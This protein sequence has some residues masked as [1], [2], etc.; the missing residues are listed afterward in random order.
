MSRR[1]LLIEQPSLRAEVALA[2]LIPTTRSFQLDRVEWDSLVI[3]RV[4]RSAAELILAVAV[5]VVNKAIAWLEWLR[6]HPSPTPSFVILPAQADEAVL[7]LAADA[8]DEFM[9]WPL[10]PEEF[11]QRLRRILHVASD[12][13]ESTHERLVQDLGLGQLVGSDPAF[14]RSIQAIPLVAKSD[15]PALITGESGTGKELCARAIHHLSRRRGCPFV[16]VDCSALPD[17]LFE[18]ELFGHSRGAY[19]DAHADQKGLVAI[20]DGGTLFLDEVDSLSLGSQAKILRFLQERTFKPLGGERFHRAD[21]NII[22]ASNADLE[23]LV[24]ERR[25]RA[26][27]FF[28]LN[29]LRLKLPPVRER[30][31]DIETLAYHVLRSIPSPDGRPRR[32][33]SKGAVRKLQLYD[34][35]GNVRELSNIVQRA[36]LL[37][38]GFQILPE[39]IS[40]PESISLSERQHGPFRQA[41]A[42]AIA[43]FERRYIEDLL[44]EHGGNVTRASRVAGKDRRAFGRLMKKH[45]IQRTGP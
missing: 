37:C 2:S 35:P 21:L 10:R 38:D 32:S 6:A 4:A 5:P 28:R 16:A 11:Q 24:R 8:A 25:F 45:R 17:L 20:A 44:R 39:H 41:K 22:A 34:W 19:T 42:E 33:F 18:N 29:V 26:D 40:L 23:A 43:V 13:V 27:L 15:V 9:L 1:L 7:R 31:N 30:R 12:E 36:V 3:D 14:V